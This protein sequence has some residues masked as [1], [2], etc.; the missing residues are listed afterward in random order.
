MS[1]RIEPMTHIDIRV[2]R[3]LLVSR[4]NEGRELLA[5]NTVPYDWKKTE[6]S[7][8]EKCKKAVQFLNE[9]IDIKEGNINEVSKNQNSAEAVSEN[10]KTGVQTQRPQ[11]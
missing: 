2:V 3:N 11:A 6:R 8:L 9:G 10:R 1:D 7:F 5:S 4:I